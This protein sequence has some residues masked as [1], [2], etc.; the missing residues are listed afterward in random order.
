MS[1]DRL[2]FFIS[3]SKPDERW[4]EWI[5]FALEEAGYRVK[6]M[7]WDFRPGSN[8]VLEMQRAATETERTLA[9]LSPAYLTSAYCAPEWAAAFAQDPASM[10]RKLL[11]V[12]VA[13]CTP[14]GLLAPI[15]YIDLHGLTSADE[16]RD[17]LLLGV[18]KGRAKPASPPA[19]PGAAGASSGV[20]SRRD[21]PAYPG[22]LPPVWMIPYRCNR[23]FTGRQQEIEFIAEYF[24]A[25]GSTSN[26][27]PLVL[28]GLGGVGK[29]QLA[30]EYAWQHHDRYDAVLWV[31]AGSE[32]ALTA[33][34]AALTRATALNLP[35]ASE[36]D[37]NVQCAAAL[38]WLRDHPRCLLIVDNV[39][40]QTAVSAVNKILPP[41][42][43]GHL[44][45]T[46]RR[47]GWPS[48]GFTTREIE[49]LTEEMAVD[50]LLLRTGEQH[51][52]PDVAEEARR[53]AKELGYL[54]LAL[55]Q[56]AA[57]LQ[58]HRLR[59]TDYLELLRRA[60]ARPLA[61]RTEG[62]TDYP[63]SVMQTWSITEPQLSHPARVLL[64]LISLLA[65]Q[66]IPRALITQSGEALCSALTAFDASCAVSNEAT[67]E[68]ALVELA[69][70]SLLTLSP[71][72]LH[73]HRLLQRVLEIGLTPEE[74]RQWIEL[75]LR[76]VNDYVVFEPYDVLAFSQWEAIH[77]HAVRIAFAAD[78]EGI[79]DPTSRLMNQLG[80]YL[81]Y[82]AQYHAAEPLMRRALAIDE[83]SFG[84]DH[85][86]VAIRLNN[87][88][89]LLQ[90]TNRLTE[91]EPLM[92]RALAIDEQSFGAEHPTV[93]I[94]LNNLATL[95][96]ATNRLVETEPLMRRA[97]AI[98][99]QS[100]GT[101]HPEVATDLN[102]LAQ[103]LQATNRLT[104]AE[105]LMRRALAIDEQSFGTDHPAVA[106]DLI[107]LAQLMKATKRLTEA[108]PLMRR[109]LEIDEQS[110]GT[111]HP[112]VATDLSNLALLLYATN[113]LA[114]A[115]P[116][117]HRALAIDEQSFGTEHPNVARD[118]NNLAL[119]L[120]DTN[121]LA[122]AKPL[123]RRAVEIL[124][125]FT[126]DTG[127]QH[128]YL[129]AVL[130]NHRQLFAELEGCTAH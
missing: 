113:R 58:R 87:L 121:R 104:E 126:R 50:F 37:V 120:Q 6:M 92:R 89:T 55:E 128:P 18:G 72:A 77:P 115:E 74:H 20:A 39:D 91:A 71:D 44:L 47:V 33:N 26:N 106:R 66:D 13:E 63:Y 24:R 108:E 129:S 111:D 34:L 119:L 56:A 12:R 42:L 105:P 97:L 73:C 35:E 83:Q 27:S 100:F 127:H 90:A 101:E 116:L 62:G 49:V 96:K 38:R 32:D 64:R 30:A 41:D 51:A 86:K 45:L 52:T 59:L 102:N 67:W 95:L 19:F 16:A 36:R 99:E 53:L 94:R 109:A 112:A 110:F 1:A 40:T 130:E 11:P 124:K 8:F 10:Q 9:V 46:A 123:M 103:L 78:K 82:R 61:E 118:L 107:N 122:E 85:P 93:A 54:P 80:Q 79:V 125:K 2:D 3:Y 7:G 5:G 98:D 4:A 81:D 14:E 15:V 23:Y 69:D 88:A 65:P 48:V 114:E 28:H 57:Y 21:T 17:K 68:D 60:P 31:T 70:Y 76:L 43:P 117:M 25:C 22:A 29:S 75:A 84:S